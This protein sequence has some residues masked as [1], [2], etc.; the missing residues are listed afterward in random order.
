MTKYKRPTLQDI[1]SY[2]GITKMTVSR[3][4]RDPNMVAKETGERIA[5]AIEQFGYI[6]NRALIFSLMPKVE[7]LACLFLHSLTKSLRM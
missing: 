3:F 5:Q 4:L 7:R 1:A 2:L 6:P